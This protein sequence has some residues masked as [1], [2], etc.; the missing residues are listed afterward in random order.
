VRC[1]DWMALDPWEWVPARDGALAAVSAP[2][3]GVGAPGE[4]GPGGL[5]AGARPFAGGRDGGEAPAEASGG[6]AGR[7]GSLGG[8]TRL[9]G[10]RNW[11]GSRMRLRR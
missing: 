6:D 1:Q 3:A 10:R 7:Q 9:P 11:S 8:G 5:G 2:E 4:W